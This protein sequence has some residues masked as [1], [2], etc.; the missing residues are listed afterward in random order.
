MNRKYILI[1]FLLLFLGI[2]I[3]AYFYLKGKT[4]TM[5]ISKDELEAT[6]SKSFPMEKTYLLVLKLTLKDPELELAQI[7]KDELSFAL[8]AE[9]RVF[10]GIKSQTYNGRAILN[11][12][13]IYDPKVHT[14]F[15]EDPYIY[16]INIQGVPKIYSD[17]L[18]KLA[19]EIIKKR[20]EHYPLY[21]ISGSSLQ[22]RIAKMTLKGV[23]VKKD[24]V[25]LYFGI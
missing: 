7:K 9:A 8:T 20:F 23:K 22:E 14:F 1:A 6:V 4:F 13:L 21:T 24:K 11:A 18:P 16:K 25:V 15:L 19:T 12:H 5:E 2:L 3:G 10:E 17:R